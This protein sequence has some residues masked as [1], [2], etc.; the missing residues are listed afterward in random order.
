MSESSLAGAESA[1]QT[2]TFIRLNRKIR[3]SEPEIRLT[4]D[5]RDLGQ[6]TAEDLVDVLVSEETTDYILDLA[7][8]RAPFGAGWL[9]RRTLDPILPDELRA[10]FRLLL[11]R[12]FRDGA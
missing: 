10:L 3:M 9:I 6:D 7:A 2:K 12:A 4:D 5:L 8:S 11:A 1:L